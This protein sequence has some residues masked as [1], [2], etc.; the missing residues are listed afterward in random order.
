MDRNNDIDDLPGLDKSGDLDDLDIIICTAAFIPLLLI[1][2]LAGNFPEIFNEG[3]P[4][5]RRRT[6]KA[7]HPRCSFDMLMEEKQLNESDTSNYLRMSR[8]SFDELALMLR[9]HLLVDESYAARR[10]GAIS[11]EYCLFMTLRYLAGARYQDICNTCRVSSTAVYDA[12]ERTMDA[13]ILCPELG[14]IFP[15]SVAECQQVAG[16]FASISTGN[17]ITNCVGAIDGFL[18]PIKVPTKAEVSNVTAYYSGHYARYGINVQAICD[19]YC[20]FTFLSASSP[21]SVNDRVAYEHCN[22]KSFVECLP[23]DYAILADA[24]YA[25]TEHCLPMYYGI[26]RSRNAKYDNYN[27]YAS[28]LR[29]R[30]EM[31]FGM[32]TRK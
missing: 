28:Q 13:I 18:M 10:G 30:I 9:D 2:V 31:A 8:K 15:K 32:M 17:A 14:L 25:P 3:S 7:I 22:V 6:S 4:N 26:K 27:Y 29:I 1:C 12:I 19:S 11:P 23:D 16:G 24:A 5:K 20:R 21:G